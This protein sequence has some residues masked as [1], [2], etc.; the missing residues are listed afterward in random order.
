MLHSRKL[1]AFLL[2]LMLLLSLAACA[3][4]DDNKEE[5]DSNL[6]DD[7]TTPDDENTSD[8]DTTPDV[9]SSEDVSNSDT[10]EEGNVSENNPDDE[11]SNSDAAQSTVDLTEFFDSLS[12]TYDLSST[13]DLDDTLIDSYLPGLKDISLVQSVLKAPMIS[14]I[15]SEILLVECENSEDVA[16]VEEIFQTRMQSQ[17]DGGAW[18]PASIEV[19]EGAQ[20][21]TEGNYVALFAHENAAAMAEEFQALFA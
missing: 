21:V 8:E 17:I 11:E 6:S 4:E 3:N 20:I 16:T 2:A 1:I 7:A 9:D 19:W 18:Y 10:T 14:A 13:S 15:V 12:E 5:N